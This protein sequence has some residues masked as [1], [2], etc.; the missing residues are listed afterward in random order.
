MSP[1]MFLGPAVGQRWPSGGPT[2]VQHSPGL[3]PMTPGDSFL[4]MMQIKKQGKIPQ[5]QVLMAFSSKK[6]NRNPEAYH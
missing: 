5:K 3:P 1:K 4:K 6:L 2:M